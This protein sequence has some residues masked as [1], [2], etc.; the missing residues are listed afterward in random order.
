M[1]IDIT[2]ELIDKWKHELA[3]QVQRS[4]HVAAETGSEESRRSAIAKADFLE[5]FYSALTCL[6]RAAYLPAT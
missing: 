6:Q 5:G 1:V 2:P 4:K 3:L